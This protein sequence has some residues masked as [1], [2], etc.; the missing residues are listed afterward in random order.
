MRVDDVGVIIVKFKGRVR[1]V[2]GGR[3]V[4][5]YRVVD[6]MNHLG[7]GVEERAFGGEGWV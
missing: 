1:G 3:D 2:V 6:S 7:D 4:D 5:I